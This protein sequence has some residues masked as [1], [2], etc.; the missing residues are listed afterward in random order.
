MAFFRFV[1]PVFPLPKKS[2]KLKLRKNE[3]RLSKKI[4]MC[5]PIMVQKR[6]V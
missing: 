3:I 5:Y 4:D 6:N 2:F 1:H